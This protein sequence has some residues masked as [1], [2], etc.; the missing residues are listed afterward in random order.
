MTSVWS[1][2]LSDLHI[3]HQKE[4]RHRYADTENR[5]DIVFYDIAT[6]ST[7]ELDIA[8]AHIPGACKDTIKGATKEGGY[9]AAK[10]E[11]KKITKYN[12]E[13]LHD[14]SKLHMI[15]LVFEHFGHCM[16]LSGREIPSL[17]GK[18]VK[19]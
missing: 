15:P 18:I 8:L 17:H 9:A 16:G 10:R 4:P 2:C 14:G 13:L 19:E 6:G 5:P 3:H 12:S 11:V 7:K 1:D